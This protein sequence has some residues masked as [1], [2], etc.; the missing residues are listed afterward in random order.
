MKILILQYDDRGD[1]YLELTELNKKSGFEHLF[2]SHETGIP[3]YWVKVF[4]V[5]EYLPN[6]DYVIWIDSDAAIINPRA[7][8]L[9]EKTMVY[10]RDNHGWESPFNA[11]VFIMRNTSTG[12]ALMEE[13]KRGYDPSRWEIVD[14]KWRQFGDWLGPN[15]EQG[16][17][18]HHL[19]EKYKDEIDVLPVEVF[20]IDDYDLITPKTFSIHFPGDHKEFIPEMIRKLRENGVPY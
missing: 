19:Y 5:A 6:Y 14:G 18:N 10:S 20:Q 1:V 13:W 17:F 11:G 4:L 15:L 16:Y 12:R 9:S 7:I 8:P 3:P 2:L